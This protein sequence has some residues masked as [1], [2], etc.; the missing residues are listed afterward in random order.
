MVKCVVLLGLVV[1]AVGHQVVWAVA[2]LVVVRR[3][4]AALVV[5]RGRWLPAR[6]LPAR[7]WWL[8]P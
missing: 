8:V 7:W 4:V 2:A 6:W 3:A 1:Q 5:V